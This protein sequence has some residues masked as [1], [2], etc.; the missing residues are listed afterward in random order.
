MKKVGVLFDLDGT[1]LD[2]SADLLNALDQALQMH[3]LPACDRKIVKT[4]VSDGSF[5]MVKAAVIQPL[6]E[7][8]LRKIQQHMLDAY[9]DVL[10]QETVFFEGMPQLLGWL[11][12]QQIPWGIVTNKQA[13]F[14]R[15]LI[16]HLNLTARLQTIVSGDTCARA[17]PYPEPMLL[18]A[19]QLKRHPADIFYLGD[20]ERD[21]Q[22]ANVSGMVSVAVSWGF[23]KPSERIENWKATHQIDQPQH[24]IPL[25]Q[26]SIEQ[27]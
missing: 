10:G 9:H 14:T 25:I 11:D 16:Q 20:A 22:A 2:S 18:A 15:P 6:Q 4:F 8:E 23:H 1:L 17:K 13:R 24:L 12:E 3:Q 19:Q 27:G 5:A 7:T 26:A 21:M